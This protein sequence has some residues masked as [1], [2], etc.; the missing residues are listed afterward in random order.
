MTEERPEIALDL[1][2]AARHLVENPVVLAEQEPSMFRLIRRHGQ[3]L[4]QWFTQRFGYRLQQNA[5]TARLL[6]STFVASHRP[7][8]TVGDQSRAFS[9]REY[10]MLALALASVVAGPNVISL[11]DLI[12][13]IRAAAGDAG[14]VL[15]ESPS[16]RRA[17]V[18]ALKWM[19][20]RGL[21]SEM[22]ERVDSY[23]SDGS[24]DAVLKV[25][26]DRVALLPLPVLSRSETTEQLLDRAAQGHSPRARMR[27]MLLEEPVV[28]RS[29]L[30]EDE[31]SELRRRLG[32]EAG[33]FDEM[34]GLRIEARA[35]GVAAIDPDNGLTDS[36]FPAAGTVGQAA[37]L[38][39]DRL[40]DQDQNPVGSSKVV[41]VVIDL[42]RDH[43]RHWSQVADD[44]ERLANEAV[45]LLVKHRLAERSL[46]EL[47]LLPAAW[48]YGADVRVEQM[49]LL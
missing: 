39:I 9:Q 40:V 21:L 30:S 5:D 26:P 34:F 27:S 18:T 37:L 42:V 47:L 24:A 41:D 3:R 31:W 14:T 19:I 46:D 49:S 20:G 8:R 43:R 6:K 11:R 38:L 28:Y 29:D 1:R 7:L 36:R 35:E 4:D 25:R 15:S 12:H 2:A 44:P 33:I 45:E 16:E 48:R 23:A 22:H 17:L 13:R 10:T 32:D